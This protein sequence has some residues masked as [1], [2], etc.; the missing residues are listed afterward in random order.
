MS[1]I[2][3]SSVLWT[4]LPRNKKFPQTCWINFFFL[5]KQRRCGWLCRTFFLVP[6]IM[7]ALG[8]GWFCFSFLCGWIVLVIFWCILAVTDALVSVCNPS[9]VWFRCILCRPTLSWLCNFLRVFVWGGLHVSLPIIPRRNR[10]PLVCTV[11]VTRRFSRFWV[12]VFFVGSCVCW[13]DFQ[14]ACWLVVLTVVSHTCRGWRW[15][16]PHLLRLFYFSL[17]SFMVSSGMSLMC[18]R[19]YSGCFSGVMR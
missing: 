14:G 8:Y 11:L 10:L 6:Y 4:A 18:M 5:V 12:L 16:I 2:G 7:G 17:Y 1:L 9:L 19:M 13:V 3:H 15:Y